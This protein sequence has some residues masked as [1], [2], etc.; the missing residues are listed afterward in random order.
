MSTM[1][2]FFKKCRL[3]TQ[4]A[5]ANRAT[6]QHP[7]YPALSITDR[8]LHLLEGPVNYRV[9]EEIC[10]ENHSYYLPELIKRSY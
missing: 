6:E 1:V 9:Q 8:N 2:L 10:K 4:K 5:T 7:A 3:F